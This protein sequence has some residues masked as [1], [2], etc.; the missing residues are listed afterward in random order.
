MARGTKTGSSGRVL[1]QPQQQPQPETS[2]QERQVLPRCAFD[3]EVETGLA[4]GKCG[5]YIC[6]RCM[7]QTPVGARCRECARVTKL[8]T[9][10]VGPSHYLRASIAGGLVA[11]VA[12]TIWSVVPHGIP[13]LPWLLAM[14]TGHLVGEAISL[15]VKPQARARTGHHRRPQHDP[16]HIGQSLPT[17]APRAVHHLLGANRGGR[18]LYR[19]KTGPIAP[20]TGAE[21]LH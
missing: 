21:R 14:A 9:F 3:P 8:P 12:G 13:F 17:A 7:I 5:K 18:I 2:W 11:V 16:G 6:P 1:E 10:D 15:S 19:H 4:C 20:A